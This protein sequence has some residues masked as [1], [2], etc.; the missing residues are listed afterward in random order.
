MFILSFFTVSC[1]DELEDLFDR[2]QWITYTINK[3]DHYSGEHVAPFHGEKIKF[4]TIFDNSAIYETVNV[5]N[6]TDIN[7]LYGFT[8]CGSSDV[9][10][11]GLIHENSTRFGWAW[12][13]ATK[14]VDI[15]AYTY[16]NKV[17]IHNYMTSVELNTE[18]TY[19]IDASGS[20]YIFNVN[21]ITTNMK[22]GCSNH[23][24]IKF[25]AFPYFGGSETAPHKI[26]VQIKELKQ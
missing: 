17:C 14:K 12:N 24:G 15:Y 11:V 23:G 20:E 19:E 2:H 3:G 18:Y 1:K 26:T 25:L 4:I 13:L 7:K 22:R 6:Q 8:D 9:F 5:S 16:V 21:G 10:D